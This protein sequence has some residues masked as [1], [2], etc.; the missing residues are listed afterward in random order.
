MLFIPKG[1][2]HGFQTLEDNS[3][4]FYQMSELYHPESARGVRFDDPCFAISWPLSSP[5]VSDRDR[6]F[7]LFDPETP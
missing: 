2:A 7:P 6:S 3:E 4:V 1:L 5:K